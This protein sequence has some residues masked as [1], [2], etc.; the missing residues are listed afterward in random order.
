MNTKQGTLSVTQYYHS[1]KGLLI[2]LNLYQ[3]MEME[4][5]ADSKKMDMFEMEW[6]LQFLL[7]LNPEFD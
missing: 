5:I 3:N 1:L 6:V 4:S 7:G 2:E